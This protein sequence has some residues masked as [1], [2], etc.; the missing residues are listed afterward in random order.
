MTIGVDELFGEIPWTRPATGTRDLLVYLHVPFCRYRCAFCDWVEQIPARELISHDDF[1]EQYV[2]ALCRQIRDIAPRLAA[3]GY[4][5]PLVYWGGGTPTVLESRQHAAVLEALSE[6]FDLTTVVEHSL[7]STPDALTAEKVQVLKSLGIR[8]I[9]VGVQ[10]MDPDQLRKSGRRHSV[11]RAREAVDILRAEGIDNFNLDVI[12][13]LPDQTMSDVHEMIETCVGLNPGHVS[14]YPYRPSAGTQL[15][16]VLRKGLRQPLARGTLIELF[17]EAETLLRSAGYQDYITGYFA[18]GDA[19]RFRGEKYY[20]GLE[21][22]FMGFGAGA[23]SILCQRRIG[24][25]RDSVSAFIENPL[26]FSTCDKFSPTL[27]EP[28]LP[29]LRPCIITDEGIRY[30]EFRR[31]FGFDFSDVR[32]HPVLRG[33]LDYFRACGAELVDEGDRLSVRPDTRTLAHLNSYGAS[34]EY[35]VTSTH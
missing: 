4:T 20:F 17:L 13:G 24:T 33:Y 14:L 18:K 22:D 1:H 2:V 23:A 35:K 28:I 34:V 9:S 15:A 12:V 30:D 32:N 27:L 16:T 7:E 3:M 29:L 6:S 19:Y 11:D 8:R 5:V 25:R 26:L 31:L 21:G 10:S